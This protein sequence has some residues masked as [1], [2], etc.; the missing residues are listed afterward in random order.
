VFGG[1]LTAGGL[2]GEPPP[3]GVHVR[4]EGKMRKWVPRVEQV[5]L[6]AR[7]AFAQG[8]EVRYITE[9]AVFVLTEGGPM[10]VEIAPGVD[11]ERDVKA[12]VEFPLKV[13][14]SLRTMDRKLYAEGP[15]GLAAA[16]DAPAGAQRRAG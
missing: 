2:K 14:D 12:Q 4:Q 13:S 1:W 9:R 16:L 3:A 10:L 6:N 11:L 5:T 15:I 7:R 8:Q